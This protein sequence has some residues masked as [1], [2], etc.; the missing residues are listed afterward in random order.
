M[1]R[2][3]LIHSRAHS[4][5]REGEHALYERAGLGLAH[6]GCISTLDDGLRWS[7]P[8]ALLDGYDAL[9]IGGSGD[10]DI[11]GGREPHD[12][13][14]LT[15]QII[16]ARLRPVIEYVL[17]HSLP[18]LGVCYG[19]QLIAEITAGKVAR[20]SGQGKVGTYPVHLT[21][22]GRQDSLFGDMPASFP[23]QYGHKD[24]IVSVPPEATILATGPSCR[25]AAL[26][27]GTRAY[28]TQFHPELTREDMMRRMQD[29]PGYLPEGVDMEALFQESLVA[30]EVIPAFIERVVGEAKV[31]I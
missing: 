22:A 18:V 2:I 13:A 20:D 25:F 17:E 1:K 16:I 6:F 30:S 24:S 4:A 9:I 21:A 31:A 7:D 27:Y 26:R 28:T 19:H 14:R 15:S 12:P 8:V 3:L 29:A 23:A 10:F 11:D 5:N